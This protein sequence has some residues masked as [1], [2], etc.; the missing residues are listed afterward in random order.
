[1]S[2]KKGVLE[3]VT[4]FKRK[5]LRWSLFFNKVAGLKPVT[6]LKRRLQHKCFPVSFAKFLRA[7]FL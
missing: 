6:Q 3:N 2:G 7:A 4:K 1:M 5:H